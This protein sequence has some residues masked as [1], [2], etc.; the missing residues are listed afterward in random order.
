[1]QPPPVTYLKVV[2]F[3]GLSGI[4]FITGHL[5]TKETGEN[6]PWVHVEP[7]VSNMKAYAWSADSTVWVQ[8][9][10]DVNNRDPPLHYL[11][12]ATERSQ[13]VYKE[14]VTWGWERKTILCYPKPSWCAV[15]LIK[16]GTK[17]TY[18]FNSVC[19][20]TNP[21]SSYMPSTYLHCWVTLSPVQSGFV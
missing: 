7:L 19:Y 20:L 8:S 10:L 14:R 11:L 5:S 17:N 1:M 3:V 12:Y 15:H 18:L 6:C 4:P 9:F 21:P 13:I 2:L 16:A